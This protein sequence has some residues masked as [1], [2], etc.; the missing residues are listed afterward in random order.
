MNVASSALLNISRRGVL[1]LVLLVASCALYL[2]TSPA[3]AG[4]VCQN[5]GYRYDESAL[6]V[7]YDIN[8]HRGCLLTGIGPTRGTISISLSVMAN[9]APDSLL[10]VDG[11]AANNR[12]ICRLQEPGSYKC[13]VSIRLSHSLEV[14]TIYKIQGVAIAKNRD[15]NVQAQRRVSLRCDT[16][17]IRSSC[18][19]V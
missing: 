5:L 19:S 14:G 8:L 12:S 18:S 16:V 9:S 2:S 13:S 7:T 17:V 11:T 3:Q 10:G 1:S 15:V 4:P 6:T